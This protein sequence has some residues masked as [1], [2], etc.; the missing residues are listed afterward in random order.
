MAKRDEHHEKALCMKLMTDL[1]RAAEE[2]G[3]GM[4]TDSEVARLIIRLKVL[5]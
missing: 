3:I 2:D 4:Y 1:I 5:S